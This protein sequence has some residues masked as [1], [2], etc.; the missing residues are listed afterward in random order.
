M[1]KVNVLISKNQPTSL[2]WFHRIT[3]ECKNEYPMHLISINRNGYVVDLGCNVGGFIEAFKDS[4]NTT[5]ILAIDASSYN[6]SEFKKNHP[7]IKVLHKAIYSVDNTTVKLKKYLGE[8]NDDTNSG[9]FSITNFICNEN[10]HGYRGEEFEE[11]E[12]IS[13]ETIL[14]T[15]NAIEL[16]KIDVEGAEYDALYGKDLS[17]IKYIVGEIHNFLGAEKQNKLFEWI[18]KTHRE[19]YSIGEGKVSHFVKMWLRE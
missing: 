8:G 1:S 15:T 14:K 16:L 9:N 17:D 10:N 19:I 11:V 4:L 13:I 3:N 2:N 18:K 5:N 7:F 12:T 6:I